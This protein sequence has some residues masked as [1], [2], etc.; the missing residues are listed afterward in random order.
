MF[1]HPSV[2]AEDHGGKG[3]VGINPWTQQ[4]LC[5]CDPGSPR[6]GLRGGHR[7]RPLNT[8]AF[9]NAPKGTVEGFLCFGQGTHRIHD[10]FYGSEGTPQAGGEHRLRRGR[11]TLGRGPESAKSHGVSA[12]SEGRERGHPTFRGGRLQSTEG[13]CRGAR[14]GCPAAFQSGS[15]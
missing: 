4:P 10:R 13:L 9:G 1:P 8:E 5:L 15:S 12:E 14:E 2:L 7:G 11:G 6:E 3:G